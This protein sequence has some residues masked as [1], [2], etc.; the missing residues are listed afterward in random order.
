[1]N[2]LKKKIKLYF[3]RLA[4]RLSAPS[5][6]EMVRVI[7]S[8]TASLELV[9]DEVVK[10]PVCGPEMFSHITLTGNSLPVFIYQVFNRK[11]MEFILVR[12]EISLPDRIHYR[13]FLCD[14]FPIPKEE[15]ECLDYYRKPFE[16]LLINLF[17]YWP[18]RKKDDECERTVS[19]S[20]P[21]YPGQA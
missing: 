17:N 16:L 11:L 19:K 18:L 10:L 15:T 4:L 7:V 5:V 9:K 3:A 21:S 8:N 2:R 1:M 13:A 6:A 14:Q 12:V 20:D